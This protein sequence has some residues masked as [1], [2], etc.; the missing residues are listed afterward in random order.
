MFKLHPRLSVKT[1]KQAL[2]A[3]KVPYYMTQ[4]AIHRTEMEVCPSDNCA[5]GRSLTCQNQRRTTA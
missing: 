5:N 4:F 1:Q 3:C 2:V